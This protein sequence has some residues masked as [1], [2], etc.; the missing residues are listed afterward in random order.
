MRRVFLIT[1]FLGLVFSGN[2]QV[3]L[4]GAESLRTLTF[5]KSPEFNDESI[6][7]SKYITEEF[8]HAKVNNGTD[9]FLIRYN[10][11]RDVMEYKN[12]DEIVELIKEQHTHFVF[13]DGT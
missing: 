6:L 12:A 1:A 8:H 11:H 9:N 10:A 2:A 5:R 13:S 7:G 3:I 4:Q